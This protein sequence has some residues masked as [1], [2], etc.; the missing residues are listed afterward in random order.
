[1]KYR[2]LKK[3]LKFLKYYLNWQWISIVHPSVRSFANSFIHLF[4]SLC[5]HL[6]VLQPYIKK[7]IYSFILKFIHFHSF[8]LKFIHLLWNSFVLTFALSLHNCFS[9]SCDSTES[10]LYPHPSTP[11][12]YL[13]T[14]NLPVELVKTSGSPNPY[15]SRYDKTLIRSLFSL[16]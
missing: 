1:M 10:T 6:F 15:I 5:I 13:W 3:Y 14:T 7:F 2:T 12:F 16:V 8:V 11:Y 4:I 9:Y